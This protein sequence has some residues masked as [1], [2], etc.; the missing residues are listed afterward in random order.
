MKTTFYVTVRPRWGGHD[1]RQLSG[2]TASSITKT[3]PGRQAGT[4]VVKMTLDIPDSAFKSIEPEVIVSVPADMVRANE[5][6]EI[7]VEDANI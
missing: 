1:R 5:P 4:V 2:I 3:R 7:E 6:I